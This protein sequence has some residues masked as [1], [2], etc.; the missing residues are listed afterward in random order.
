[1]TLVKL[2]GHGVTMTVDE[3]DIALYIQ[4]GYKRTSGEKPE[5]KAIVE[6]AKL[7]DENVISDETKSLTPEKQAAIIKKA[8]EART[9]F[10]E[11]PADE[12]VVVKKTVVEKPVVE[13]HSFPVPDTQPAEKPVVETH[14]FD[15]PA[16]KTVITK[17]PS[18]EPK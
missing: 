4:A 7:L 14:R 8:D 13:D 9:A 11:D 2:I 10:A 17:A 18:K 6:E 1:M 12:K 3:R 15:E 16:V 5:D